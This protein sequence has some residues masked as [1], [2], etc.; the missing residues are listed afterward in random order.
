MQESISIQSFGYSEMYEWMELP[1]ENARLARFVTFSEKDP[2]RIELFGKKDSGMLLGITTINSTID[3]DDPKEWK[4]KYMVTE[5]G[6]CVLQR[7]RLAVATKQYDENLEMAF[8]RTYP[9]E[10]LIKVENKLYDPS[11]EYVP[12]SSRGEWARVNLMGKAIVKDNGKCKG[13]EYCK[14]YV[15]KIKDRMGTAVPSKSITDKNRFYV[16]GRINENMILI[17]NK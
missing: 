14:P 15:G 11:K 9:W 13:G 1:E 2:N 4:Y 12:R 3:S 8:I 17:V 16:L 10:H 5:T 6:D 7:E